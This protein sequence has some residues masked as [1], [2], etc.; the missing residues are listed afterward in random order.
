MNRTIL[1]TGSTDGIGKE[2]ALELAS[3]GH[4]VIMHGKRR[5]A[6]QKLTEEFKAKTGNPEIYYY[7]ADLTDLQQI[8][9]LAESIKRNFSQLDVLLNNAGV[10]MNDKVILPNGFEMTQMVNHLAVFALTLQLLDLVKQSPSGRIIVTSSMAHS[11]SIDFSNLNGEKHWDSYNA[12][13]VSK[14]ENILFTYKL[15]QNLTAEN[16]HVTANCLHPGVISTKLLHAGWGMGGG[17]VQQGAS[18]SVYLAASEEVKEVSGKYF[19]NKRSQKSAAFS[20][21]HKAQNKLWQ[22]SSKIL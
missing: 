21:D 11:S 17:S 10:F 16:S 6:G 9:T 7:N 2:A 3:M 14:L 1:V 20:Y 4:R 13:A 22:I 12:Y 8:K 5:Q 19:V 18:T 15:H